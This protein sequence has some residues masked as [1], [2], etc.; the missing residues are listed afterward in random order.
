MFVKIALLDKPIWHQGPLPADDMCSA[1]CARTNENSCFNNVHGHVAD[2]SAQTQSL[3]NEARLTSLYAALAF[4]EVALPRPRSF[5]GE[6]R[7][8][9]FRRA[10]LILLFNVPTGQPLTDA[11][12]A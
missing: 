6:R 7:A 4:E 10:R 8:R 1:C 11:A 9:S 3:A 5:G 12:A 2:A